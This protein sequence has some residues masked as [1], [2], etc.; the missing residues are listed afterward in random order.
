MPEHGIPG[1]L[2]YLL[3]IPIFLLYLLTY[4]Y[5]CHDTY[6]K[7]REQFMGINSLFPF[8]GFQGSN[9]CHQALSDKHIYS[10]NHLISPPH[11]L[12][13]F[14]CPSEAPYFDKILVRWI[15]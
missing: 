9:S 11:W 3:G 6:L 5:L 7:I 13:T 4:V 10:Q 8:C 1:L 14:G 15:C 2:T 12:F